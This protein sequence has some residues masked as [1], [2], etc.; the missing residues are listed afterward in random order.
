M[1]VC[2]RA[3]A[4]VRVCGHIIIRSAGIPGD[5][6]CELCHY[7]KYSPINIFFF[8]KCLHLCKK[9]LLKTTDNALLA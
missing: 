4:R 2:V 9:E 5:L 3:S 8:E 7:N 6:L 1:S